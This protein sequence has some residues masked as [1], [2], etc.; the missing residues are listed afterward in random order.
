M[1][2]ELIRLKNQIGCQI[3]QQIIDQQSYEVL[4]NER[5]G[6]SERYE[7]LLS[8]KNPII[9][10]LDGDRTPRTPITPRTPQNKMKVSSLHNNQTQMTRVSTLKQ[11]F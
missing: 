8:L 6:L 5:N 7:E 1:E 9:K 3:R 10:Q 11:Y 2:A 4:L